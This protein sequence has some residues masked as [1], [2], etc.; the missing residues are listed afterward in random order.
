MLALILMALLTGFLVVGS[1]ELLG[2]DVQVFY[3]GPFIILTLLFLIN[4][5]CCTL[6]QG[7]KL[8]AFSEGSLRTRGSSRTI[9][10]SR[11]QG[12]FLF[13]F[14]LLVLTSGLLLQSQVGQKQD[15][16][17]QEGGPP[18]EV[19]DYR[20]YL[21]QVRLPSSGGKVKPKGLVALADEK[22]AVKRSWV[23]QGSPL[24]KGPNRVYY[25]TLGYE[26][27]FTLNRESGGKQVW[28]ARLHPSGT[29]GKA[30]YTGTFGISNSPGTVSMDFQPGEDKLLLFLETG[31]GNRYSRTLKMG[32]SL[33]LPGGQELNFDSYVPLLSLQY[34][35]QPG[36]YVIN[37]GLLI[38]TLGLF[39][40]YFPWQITFSGWRLR[41]LFLLVLTLPFASPFTSGC[42]ANQDE[43]I[44]RVLEQYNSNLSLAYQ[45]TTDILRSVVTDREQG[46]LDIFKAQLE[47]QN[48]DIQVKQES[49]QIINITYHQAAKEPLAKDSLLGNDYIN[50]KQPQVIDAQKLPAATIKT[51]ELWSYRYLDTATK[52]PLGDW[53]RITYQTTYTMVSIEKHW[54]INDLIFTEKLVKG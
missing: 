16:L 53:Q 11:N 1:L 36:R 9:C 7:M 4:L 43:Q 13:H 6:R 49:M 41:P 51:E 26:L 18:L 15:V 48:K 39:L 12:S 38:G 29:K 44:S 27:Y 40:L 5:A 10:S 33:T 45:D 21:E 37:A 52:K 30:G 34:R 8:L 54:F 42:T 50:R 25:N 2:A 32:Q 22:G 35:Y 19:K 17:L 46:R 47:A 20:I 23:Q 3:S 24:A 31:S 14:G 28:Q